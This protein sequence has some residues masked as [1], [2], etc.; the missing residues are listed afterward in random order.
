MG[1]LRLLL[2]F[3]VVMYHLGGGYALSGF[4]AVS[5]FYL[6]SGYLMAGV[7]RKSYSVN[8]ASTLLFYLNRAI[9]LV[10]L[11]LVFALV[12]VLV[13]KILMSNAIAALGFNHEFR[14][15]ME[16][17]AFAGI[18]T[19]LSTALFGWKF[20]TPPPLITGTSQIIP[21]IWSLAVEGTFY[22]VVPLIVLLDRGS[23][24]VLP[25]IFL[26][27]CA[28]TAYVIAADYEFSTYVY[29]NFFSSMIFF[30][31]GM[32]LFH[33]DK[34]V[35]PR[36]VIPLLLLSSAALA[37]MLLVKI[38]DNLII[39]AFYA[40]IIPISIC[41]VS[42]RKF[43]DVYPGLRKI[44][45][46][47]GSLSY[48]VYLNHFIA[49]MVLIA[50]LN[51]GL[52]ENWQLFAPLKRPVFGLLCCWIAVIMA[53]AVQALIEPFIDRLRD[54]VR[55][56]AA[57]GG[58]PQFYREKLSQAQIAWILTIFSVLPLTVAGWAYAT[59]ATT[60][61]QAIAQ[62]D[63]NAFERLLQDS[64]DSILILAIPRPDLI[65][66]NQS[67]MTLAAAL[68]G[69]GWRHG[70]EL[71]ERRGVDMAAPGNAEGIC[72]AARFGHGSVARYFV[73]Q[74]VR[75]NDAHLP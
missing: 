2:A 53:M 71:L 58:G 27:A 69:I 4:G 32:A 64:P 3:S 23:R 72:L 41:I 11:A 34:Y 62:R 20:E 12:T 45:S 74:G 33:L 7:V 49:G 59:A 63:G 18:G 60:T 14:D 46:Y 66:G 55:Q 73:E 26:A 40:L 54:N 75:P 61:E 39:V 48:A 52:G 6:L 17:G 35:G 15:I 38:Q 8:F 36:L 31:A 37:Y 56:L 9:R 10:P 1:L 16:H 47:L 30:S 50:M 70:L 22:L 51:L 13:S 21:Q 24:V 57:S 67:E 5:G 42:A 68:G 43:V 29:K 65:E 28:F 44:D 19:I 25:V